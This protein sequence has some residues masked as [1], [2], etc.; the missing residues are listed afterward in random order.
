MHS[1]QG[2]Y[3]CIILHLGGFIQQLM[4]FAKVLFWLFIASCCLSSVLIWMWSTLSGFG[5]I[6]P[7]LD[8]DLVSLVWILMWSQFSCIVLCVV[9]PE[10]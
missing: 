10:L 1:E 7:C 4:D 3:N 6:L 2:F 5:G 9:S 8:L